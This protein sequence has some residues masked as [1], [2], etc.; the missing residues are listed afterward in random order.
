M[1][2]GFNSRPP[3]EDRV[4]YLRYFATGARGGTF[5][6]RDDDDIAV[7][8]LFDFENIRTGWLLF[9]TG[10]PPDLHWDATPGEPGPK[11]GQGHRRGLCVRIFFP[12][13]R[14]VRELTTST[15]GLCAAIDKIYSE[16]GFAPQRAQGLVPL[17]ECTNVTPS[18]TSFGTIFDPEFTIVDWQ[19]RPRLLMP[20][21]KA[22][23]ATQSAKSPGLPAR[24][25][26]LDDA[27][28][29]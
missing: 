14:G 5:A 3:A 8:A 24:R 28:P 11:P 10:M 4:P 21:T 6:D 23:R 2:L 18:E 9:E 25:D 19:P 12:D 20:P 1:P 22:R 7:I 26:E 15:A 13:G 27:V 16:F 29:F 17:V